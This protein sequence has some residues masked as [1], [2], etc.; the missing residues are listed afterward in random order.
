MSHVLL[1][2][3]FNRDL[4][5]KENFAAPPLGPHRLASW[6]RKHGH[7]ALV[8][9]FN[10][11]DDFEKYLR[12]GGAYWDIIGFSC[13]QVSLPY[14]IRAARQAKVVCPQARIVFG[15]IEAT[16]NPQDI[17][18]CAPCDLVA[19]GEGEE[20]LLGLADGKPLS[21]LSGYLLRQHAQPVSE[22]RFA[23]WWEAVDFSALEYEKY[24]A[25]T[26]A[27][28]PEAPEEIVNTIRLITSSHCT[29]GCA[30]CSVTRWKAAACGAALPTVALSPEQVYRVVCKA[31]EQVPSVKSFYFCEDDF[32][33]SRERAY[34]AFQLLG[35]TGRQFMIQTRMDKLTEPLI[36]HLARHGCRHITMGIENA[37]E[38]VLKAFGKPQKLEMVS[39]VIHWCRR[40]GVTPYLLFILFG[41]TA[42]LEDLK[43]NEERISR[44][45]AEGATVSI[46]P[47][48]RCYRGSPLWDSSHDMLYECQPVREGPAKV[49]RRQAIRTPIRI[50]PDDT[51]ARAVSI[52][53]NRRWPEFLAAKQE[54]HHFKGATG[55]HMIE[56]LGELLKELEDAK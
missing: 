22:A 11:H 8:Y 31:I 20:L 52:E 28:E 51:E 43:M 27:L 46:E 34:K 35:Q 24:W 48:M 54:S 25:Q 32:I 10:I 49:G 33:V 37:S 29:K 4:S 9:D 39:E 2:G 36:E 26:R 14:D 12:L 41:P 42:T 44:W 47:N 16:L 23:E 38:A 45:I 18:D 5:V 6:L 53:F 21:Q 50:L 56:L 17:L 55:K 19:L 3:P 15:G 13:L 7:L 1:C 40:Y 30:F